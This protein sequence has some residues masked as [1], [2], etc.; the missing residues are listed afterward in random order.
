MKE[1]T[2]NNISAV[3]ANKVNSKLYYRTG[4]AMGYGYGLKM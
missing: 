2:E 1:D 4:I 3:V